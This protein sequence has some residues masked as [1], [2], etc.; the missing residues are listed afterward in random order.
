M[1]EVTA[2]NISKLRTSVLPILKDL[3]EEVEVD[4]VERFKND[5]QYVGFFVEW[6]KDIETA[7]KMV[8]KALKWR[9]SFGLKSIT[10]ESLGEDVLKEGYLFILGRAVDGSRV[11][12][13]RTGKLEKK[14]RDRNQRLVAFWFERIQRAEPGKKV[15]ILM[16]TTDSKLMN[17]DTS[18]SSFIIECCAAYFPGMMRKI[19]I[20]NLPYLLNAFWKL[21]SKMLSAEQR[22]AT[23][24]CGKDDLLQHI[25]K[26]N[27]TV[28]MGGTIDY[29][30]SY[31]PF[32]DELQSS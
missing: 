10:P 1:L 4:D 12:H 18:S 17:A 29:T 7:V 30:Y 16:D 23:A 25:D 24:L 13:F 5:D 3:H 22:A 11:L 14:D 31:P 21:I 27:L 9:K 19:I 32:P 8:I 20:Y 15:T 26:D 6:N 28:A 2:D